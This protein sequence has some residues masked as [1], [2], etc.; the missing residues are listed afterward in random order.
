MAAKRGNMVYQY[1]HPHQKLNHLQAAL[2][3]L[4]DD[5]KYQMLKYRN[6]HQV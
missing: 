1:H 3:G 5:S 6:F 4:S 2:D